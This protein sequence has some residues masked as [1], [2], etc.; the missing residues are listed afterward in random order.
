[1]PRRRLAVESGVCHE[2]VPPWW[3]SARRTRSSSSRSPQHSRNASTPKDSTAVEAETRDLHRLASRA[4][5]RGSR[6]RGGRRDRR[7]RGD[8]PAPAR[9]ILDD[10]DDNPQPGCG[11]HGLGG[12]GEILDPPAARAGRRVHPPRPAARARSPPCPSRRRCSPPSDSSSPRRTRGPAP[13][14]FLQRLLYEASFHLHQPRRLLPGAGAQGARRTHRQ[15]VRGRHPLR[16]VLTRK[17]GVGKTTRHARC[18]AWRSPTCAKT[19]SSPSTPIPTAARSPSASPSRPARRCATS[20]P[21]ADVDQ[22]RSPTSPTLVSRDDD[23]ARHARLATP[24]RLL[25]EAFDENDY[26]VVADLAARFYSVVLTDCGTGIVHSV[27]RATLQRADSIVVVSG[28]SVDEARLASETL[29]WLE[30]NGYGELVRNAVVALNTG[31]A[32]HQPRQ[33]R[34]DRGALPLAGARDRAHPVRPAARRRLGHPATTSCARTR[35]RPRATS[36]RSS[37][38]A[39][40]CTRDA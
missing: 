25:S 9:R 22:R 39:C 1:M 6:G 16:A 24:I 40:P 34:G 33:A 20:S 37:S 3:S 2:E 4:G 31:D 35:A 10:D 28:G 21:A 38:T 26:N 29:T 7:R 12:R 30:A 23:P 13:E 8:R 36:P 15:A 17:G 18:S 32:G 5:A 19:G 11:A 14:G 27:M